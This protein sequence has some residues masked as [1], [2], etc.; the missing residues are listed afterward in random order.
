MFSFTI[1]SAV[2]G[3]HVH[4]AIWEN[5]A[6]G[7]ELG[8]RCEVGNSHDPLSVAVIK[9]IHEE[10]TII[11][12]IPRRIS[13]LCNALFDEVVPFSVQL[14]EAEDILL[15]CLKEG[16]R[17]PVSFFFEFQQKNCAKRLKGWSVLHYVTRP[18]H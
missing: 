4:K 10:D 1:S 15:I 16:S 13:A 18:F 2:R 11:G 6:P 17:C 7:E 5:P 3:F 8:C 14:M 12:H 9:Q